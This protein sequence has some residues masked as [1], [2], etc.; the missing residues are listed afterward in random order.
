[1]TSVGSGVVL[2]EPKHSRWFNNFL[3]LHHFFSLS[4]VI[5]KTVGDTVLKISPDHDTTVKILLRSQFVNQIVRCSKT[6]STLIA[7]SHTLWRKV[8]GLDRRAAAWTS[9]FCT[10]TQAVVMSRYRHV[11][12]PQVSVS[13]TTSADA[14]ADVIDSAGHPRVYYLC[15]LNRITIDVR[16][17]REV[18]SW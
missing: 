13:A 8:D 4:R 7:F 12:L 11:L 17:E 6:V 18:T 16:S 14:I 1:M 9:T 15:S 10:V 5:L 3:I 2:V